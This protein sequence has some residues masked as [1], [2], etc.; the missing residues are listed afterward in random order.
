M[1][2]IV[3]ATRDALPSSDGRTW[4]FRMTDRHGTVFVLHVPEQAKDGAEEFRLFYEQEHPDDDVFAWPQRHDPS[5]P[6]PSAI[7]LDEQYLDAF[8]ADALIGQPSG[9]ESGTADIALPQV[10]E[11]TPPLGMTVDLACDADMP[12]QDDSLPNEM[13]A[14]SDSLILAMLEAEWLRLNALP[15]R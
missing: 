1:Q 7:P 8:V 13:V 3:F 12:Q 2:E 6:P 11:Q 4:Q 5:G 10:L 14:N 15:L 9:G